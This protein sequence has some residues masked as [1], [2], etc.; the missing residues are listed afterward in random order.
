MRSARFKI[1]LAIIE[2]RPTERDYYQAAGTMVG[3]RLFPQ[4]LTHRKEKAFL[5]PAL[6]WL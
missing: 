3:R 1:S 6:W 5:I 2:P 4:N